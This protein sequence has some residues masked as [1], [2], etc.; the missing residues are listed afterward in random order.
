MDN[1]NALKNLINEKTVSSL[2]QEIVEVYPL[3]KRSEFLRVGKKLAPLELKAR[4][5]LLA[6]ELYVFLPADYKKAL[7]IILKVLNKKKMK[8]S[9][10][11][12]W[13]FSEFIGTYGLDHF[14]ESM[15][16]MYV[17]TQHFTSEFAVR[18]FILKNHVRVLKYFSKWASDKNKH[19][20]RWVS[21]G[22]RPLLPWGGNI[23]LFIMNPTHTLLLLEKLKYDD[24]LYVRKSVANHLNDIS[25][26]HPHVVIQ[27][28]R[29]WEKDSP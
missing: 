22:S 25:K 26:N 19:V 12:L 10:F 7:E 21:E 4:V 17:L 28:L 11:E 24:E 6:N 27:M 9:G 13:P 1:E 29:A 5:K 15:K 23:P 20:R 8:L 18:P 2:G 3:F 14:D 16:A